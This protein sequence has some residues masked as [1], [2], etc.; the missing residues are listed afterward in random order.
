MQ[1]DKVEEESA[2]VSPRVV[3]RGSGL[4]R[5]APFSVARGAS[6]LGAEQ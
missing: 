5:T 2:G 6:E 1:L 4:R 3:A